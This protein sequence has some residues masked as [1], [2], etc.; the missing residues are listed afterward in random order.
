MGVNAQRGL[1]M[2]QEILWDSYYGEEDVGKIRA[3]EEKYGITLPK[4]YVDIVSRHSGAFVVDKNVFDFYS[5]L[6]R[7]EVER[8]VGMFLP[9][10]KIEGSNETMEIKQNFQPQGLPKG[11]VM[12]MRY[13]SITVQI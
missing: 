8:G 4:T 5:N 7:E 12:E 1:K 3:F 13:V 6:V 10:K 9:F 11:L 2:T